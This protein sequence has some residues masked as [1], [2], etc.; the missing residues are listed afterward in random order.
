MSWDSPDGLTCPLGLLNHYVYGM[1]IQ[2]KGRILRW[3]V[4]NDS[5]DEFELLTS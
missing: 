3:G 1:C 4:R 2:A 5:T